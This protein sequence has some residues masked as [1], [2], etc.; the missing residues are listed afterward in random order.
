MRRAKACEKITI[1]QKEPVIW[2]EG[3][4]RWKAQKCDENECWEFEEKRNKKERERYR[5]KEKRRREG[6]TIINEMTQKVFT[7]HRHGQARYKCVDKFLNM[8]EQRTERSAQMEIEMLG[9]VWSWKEQGE[10]PVKLIIL[11]DASV[12]FNLFWP[13]FVRWEC[14]IVL[15][16]VLNSP[17]C[18]D[19]RGRVKLLV[20]SIRNLNA[21][22][23][24]RT[25]SNGEKVSLGQMAFDR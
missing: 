24:L 11:F 13:L 23:W 15:F 18:L 10:N 14:E 22:E 21:V 9:V 1:Y 12:A 16:A 17:K 2:F 4:Y 25:K 20:S 3:V 5:E 6:F 8:R 19:M 7:Y